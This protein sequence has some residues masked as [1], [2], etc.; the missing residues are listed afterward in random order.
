MKR[1][2]FSPALSPLKKT[3]VRPVK[4]TLIV[5]PGHILEQWN[6]EITRHTQ[7]GA[8][9]VVPYFGMPKMSEAGISMEEIERADVVLT[10]YDALRRD[11]Y[12]VQLERTL[13]E[14]QKDR[15][16]SPLLLVQWW[17]VCMDEAQMVENTTTKA[18]EMVLRLSTVNRWA[19]TGTPIHRGLQ[20][21]MGI[22][23]FLGSEP[24]N[25]EACWWRALLE[26]YAGGSNA[27]AAR[28]HK[29][30]SDIFWRTQKKDVKHE[31]LLPPQHEVTEMLTFSPIELQFYRVQHEECA[32]NARALLD[33]FKK[34]GITN[35]D[36][37][38][39]SQGLLKIFKLRQACS[40]PQVPGGPSQEVSS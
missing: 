35:F 31:L 25:N 8:L 6:E 20:D 5:C 18:A 29:W 3:C 40:H 23:L 36:S 34:K 13:R 9:K 21:L 15:K 16:I 30:V 26:L 7:V 33:D 37:K 17:R 4:A 27:A 38:E 28:A 10:T 24:W 32:E 11:V 12:H 1:N 14:V 22:A 19:V 2:A 39:W